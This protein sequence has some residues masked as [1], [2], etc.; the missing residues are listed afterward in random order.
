MSRKDSRI[1]IFVTS[2]VCLAVVAAVVVELWGEQRQASEP[3]AAAESMPALTRSPTDLGRIPASA[4]RIQLPGGITLWEV[5]TAAGSRCVVAD[6]GAIAI[7][8][9][10]TA[11]PTPIAS[12]TPEAQ[13]L[14]FYECVGAIPQNAPGDV[15]AGGI[16]R[17]GGLRHD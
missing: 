9:G 17:C 15:I 2:F 11:E 7:S 5:D 13:R 12:L 6:N 8:C 4:N 3:T 1:L 16:E 10:F 14:T